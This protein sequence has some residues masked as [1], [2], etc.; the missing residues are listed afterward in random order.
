MPID[1]LNADLA[2]LREEISRIDS[3]DTARLERLQQLIDDMQR[4]L[5]AGNGV[6]DTSALVDELNGIVHGF[7]ASYPN[8]SAIISNVVLALGNMGV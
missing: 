8:L 7:E 2:K 4:E 3:T 6:G 1:R 5:D